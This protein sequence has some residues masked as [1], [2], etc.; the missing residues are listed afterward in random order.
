MGKKDKIKFFQ[1]ASGTSLSKVIALPCV[2]F[3]EKNAHQRVFANSLSNVQE[4]TTP[5][6]SISRKKNIR[7]KLNKHQCCKETSLQ[8]H[9]L[10]H[11][12]TDSSK[13][14]FQITLKMRLT[15]SADE[16]RIIF[17]ISQKNIQHLEKKLE[18]YF[19]K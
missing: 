12:T 8:Q 5:H 19:K 14:I 7:E 9:Q 1:S 17:K 18:K 13:Q 16:T 4:G 2:L 10:P 6:F 3:L 15:D 11:N